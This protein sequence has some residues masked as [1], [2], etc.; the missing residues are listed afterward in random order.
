MKS[1]LIKGNCSAFQTCSMPVLLWIT[2]W[3]YLGI[4]FLHIWFDVSIRSNFRLPDN[5][6]FCIIFCII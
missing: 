6:I 2:S 5:M 3:L 1:S 4:R